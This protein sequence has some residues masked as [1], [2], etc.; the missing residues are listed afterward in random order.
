MKREVKELEEIRDKQME[1]VIELLND[2][3]QL[4][5]EKHW[6]TRTLVEGLS[7]LA[8]LEA[9]ITIGLANDHQ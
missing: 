9:S 5:P 1:Y 8:S 3:F 6:Q 4:P 7:S 2:M